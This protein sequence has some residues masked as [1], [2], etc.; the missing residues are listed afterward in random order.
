LAGAQSVN[1]WP[2]DSP[3]D[4]Y[5]DVCALVERERQ[6]DAAEGVEIAKHVEGF[7]RRKVNQQKK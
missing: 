2:Y 7:V 1:L 3:Q 6:K 4:V 5:S